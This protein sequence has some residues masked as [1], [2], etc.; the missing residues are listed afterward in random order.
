MRFED[1]EPIYL[2]ILKDMGYDRNEDEYSARLLSD[3]MGGMGQSRLASLQN[4]E[5]L[6][7]GNDILICGNAPLLK[8]ELGE[9]D[10]SDY[11][12]IAADGATEVLIRA[13]I[14]PHIIVTDLDGAIETEIE[15]SQ[16]GSVL[17]VH[18]HGD[19][20]PVIKAVV[21]QLYN[22]IGSTQ[23]SPLENVFNFGGFTD[24]DRCVFLALEFGADSITLAGFDFED[25]NLPENKKKK[26]KWARTLIDTVCE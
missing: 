24:G 12:V 16:K 2:E 7:E 21:P 17:V 9:I 3:I 19:N 10:T 23:A 22:V 13:G 14:I 4:L 20:I 18:A 25:P 15:A 1:W 8:Y 6:I 11:C 26:L 5:D